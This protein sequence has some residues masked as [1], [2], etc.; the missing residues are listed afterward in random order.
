LSTKQKPEKVTTNLPAGRQTKK[1]SHPCRTYQPHDLRL[2]FWTVRGQHSALGE[3][4]IKQL[5]IIN[6][7]VIKNHS[8]RPP[9]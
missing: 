2:I 3:I 7:S 1:L 4:R 5:S 9:V 6:H 8:Q